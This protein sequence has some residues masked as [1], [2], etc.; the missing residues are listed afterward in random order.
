MP[1]LLTACA[2]TG[3]PIDTGIEIEEVSFARLPPFEGKLL[4]RHCGTEHAWS[5]AA[6]WLEKE[7]PA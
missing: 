3:Q 2:V 7:D 4:C 1:K 6:T 5:K